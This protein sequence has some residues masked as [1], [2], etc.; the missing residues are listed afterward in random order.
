[1]K[2]D[3]WLL[4][5]LLQHMM[6][7]VLNM[8]CK[9][10]SAVEGPMCQ[11]LHS[12]CLQLKDLLSAPWWGSEYLCGS[13]RIWLYQCF[14]SAVLLGLWGGTVLCLWLYQ[15]QDRNSCSHGLLWDSSRRT[16]PQS[17]ITKA[18]IDPDTLFVELYS[19]LVI[20]YWAQKRESEHKHQL[21]SLPS[22]LLADETTAHNAH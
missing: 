9:E 2:K 21:I 7:C 10:F 5:S 14:I 1:M 6:C 11:L 13:Q 12:K 19:G 16:A 4:N 17:G 15:H 3:E 18:S 8:S 20:C 22:M